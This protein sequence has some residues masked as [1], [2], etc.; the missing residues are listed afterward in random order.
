MFQ[1]LSSLRGVGVACFVVVL[2]VGCFRKRDDDSSSTATTSSTGGTST[3]SSTTSGPGGSGGSPVVQWEVEDSGTAV[4]LHGVWIDEAG[5]NAFAVGAAG[6]IVRSDDGGD[7]WQAL[8]SNVS[9]DLF[10]VFGTGTE[11]YVVGANGVI[12]HSVDGMQ[13]SPEDSQTGVDLHSV[14]ASDPAR[15]FVG[16]AGSLVLRSIDGGTT[17]DPRPNAAS[18]TITGIWGLDADTVYAVAEAAL[19]TSIDGGD[20]WSYEILSINA[21]TDV[22]VGAG[23]HIF[24]TNDG[25]VVTSWESDHWLKTVFGA[26]SAMYGIWGAS[27][28]DLYIVGQWGLIART[29]D[30][31][32]N[33]VSEDA[34]S[35]ETLRAVHGGGDRVLAVGDAGVIVSRPD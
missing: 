32:V 22:W 30:A 9:D 19:I 23:G 14:W 10:G 5:A 4:D 24:I 11:I 28:N 25:G 18:T 17:W 6:T 33:W 16:G 7:S 29:G 8:N 3:V 2:G 27:V 15:V 26:N 1:V 35:D 34:G 12:L 13:F 20:Q 31:G 21:H